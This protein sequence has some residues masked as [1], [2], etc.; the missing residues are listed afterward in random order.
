MFFENDAEYLLLA[1]QKFFEK[2]I[3][4]NEFKKCQVRDIKDVLGITSE[5]NLKSQ[6]EQKI[7]EIMN[8][9]KW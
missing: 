5:I 9:Q 7:K 3:S 2:G 6:R 8:K 1:K 4:P